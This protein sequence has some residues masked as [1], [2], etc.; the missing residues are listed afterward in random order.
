MNLDQFN[1]RFLSFNSFKI[2]PP[3]IDHRIVTNIIAVINRTM[4][5]TLNKIKFKNYKNN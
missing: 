1:G 3:Y 5:Q 4:R 2:R